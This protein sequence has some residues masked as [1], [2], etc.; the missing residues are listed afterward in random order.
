MQ[1]YDV[2]SAPRCL[3]PRLEPAGAFHKFWP[4]RR[5]GG[6]FFIGAVGDAPSTHVRV[7][8][9]AT[10]HQRASYCVLRPLDASAPSNGDAASAFASSGHADPWPK[11][12]Y[13]PTTDI[14]EAR[15][16]TAGRAIA[17]VLLNR[18]QFYRDLAAA[19]L[20]V[21][22][23]LQVKQRHRVIRVLKIRPPVV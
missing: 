16:S 7:P 8:A 13:V 17:H 18:H 15:Q 23:L 21:Q 20:D 19:A 4:C 10:A 22:W 3:C 5:S 9:R 2:A 1:R 14:T 6:A 11:G 12:G